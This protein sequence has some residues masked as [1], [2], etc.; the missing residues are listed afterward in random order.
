MQSRFGLALW[1]LGVLALSCAEAIWLHLAFTDWYYGWAFGAFALAPYLLLV[2]GT[3]PARPWLWARRIAFVLG[4]L[5]WI[6][7]NFLFILSMETSQAPWR[8]WVSAG[9]GLI[10]VAAF[11]PRRLSVPRASLSPSA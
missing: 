9:V 10:L 2:L 8:I 6:Y 5:W 4:A 1:I 3:W 11:A 7:L